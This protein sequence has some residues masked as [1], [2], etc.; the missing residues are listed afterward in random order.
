MTTRKTSGLQKA[1][2]NA[3]DVAGRPAWAV[4]ENEPVSAE[5]S[6]WAIRL[7]L[8]RPPRD[9]AEIEFH[10][11]NADI[12]RLRRAF[13][14]TAEFKRF[15]NS[16]APYRAPL[17]LLSPPDD[18]AAPWRL[19]PPTL[20]A[21]V[22]QLCTYDQMVSDGYRELVSALGLTPSLHRKQWE[23][24]Y[25]LAV[26]RQSGVLQAGK[27]A[28][29]FGVGRE[30]TP[31][32]LARF[33]LEVVATDAPPEAIAGVGW[34]TTNQHSAALDELHHPRLVD[35][36]TFRR[37]VS[38]RPVDMNAIP[39]DLEGF[40]VCWSSCC[41][42]HL[43]S[44]K[45]GLDFVENSLRTLKPGGWAVHTTEFNLDSN[46]QTVETPTL[47]LFRKRDFEDLAG[48]LVADG[49][50][51]LPLNFHPGDRELDAHIDVPPYGP[52]HLKL[53]LGM[54]TC[55]SFGIAVRKRAA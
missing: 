18:P 45:H 2:R 50:T 31:S 38:F 42:E 52:Q 40:D 41:F 9:D 43:G 14:N 8:G 29:G 48:R 36:E 54:V 27:R 22:S 55:T 23:F 51:V 3:P 6:A 17:F 13:A 7:F 32:L 46:A 16:G 53:M 49:H 20:E 24:A 11:K 12:A 44:I 34:E 15:F 10:R 39:D 1:E 37:Q 4:D 25:I 26:M 35:R 47:S 28:L 5:A 19:E 30:P 21:P 33:G